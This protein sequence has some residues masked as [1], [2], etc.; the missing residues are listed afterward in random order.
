MTV[1]TIITDLYRHRK[2]TAIMKIYTCLP[3]ICIIKTDTMKA[4]RLS[5]YIFGLSLIIHTAVLICTV[6]GI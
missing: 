3:H 4:K 2:M 1:I 6:A 5:I